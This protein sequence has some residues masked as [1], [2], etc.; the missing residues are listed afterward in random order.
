[1]RW[2]SKEFLLKY[3]EIGPVISDVKLRWAQ[4]QTTLIDMIFA[5]RQPLA[6]VLE[7]VHSLKKLISN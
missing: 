1:M 5:E 6:S 4:A 7:R 2:E 3:Q